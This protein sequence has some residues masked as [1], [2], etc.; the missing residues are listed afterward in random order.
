MKRNRNVILAAGAATLLLA[1]IIYA[2][3]FL[4]PPIAELYGWEQTSGKLQFN[5]TLTLIFYCVGGLFSGFSAK[6][7]APK[8][9]LLVSGLLVVC[10]LTIVSRLSGKSPLTLYLGYGA[11]T[12]TG[13]GI[14]Y[15]TLVAT[16]T[17]HFPDKKGLASGL[18]MLGFGFSAF[19]LGNLASALFETSFGWRNVFLIY[20][21][22]IGAVIMLAAFVIVPPE[23]KAEQAGVSDGMSVAESVRRGSYW[24]AFMFFVC[25]N[26]L[27]TTAIGMSTNLMEAVGATGALIT[28]GAGMVSVFNGVSR[29]FWGFLFDRLGIKK[30]RLVDIVV[31]MLSPLLLI[32]ALKAKSPALCFIAL[33][34]TGVAFAYSPTAT[35]NYL[36]SFYG[37]RSFNMNLSIHTLSLIPGSLFATITGGMEMMSAYILLACVAAVGCAL[38]A[39]TYKA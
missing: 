11:M 26:A 31:L 4:K 19:A 3:S 9:R 39:M 32:L 36:L 34:L 27:C 1:G 33:C 37:G 14:A 7:L 30:T 15:N 25:I 17:A 22:V 13:I 38:S 5:Y 10:G 8:I 6:V 20:G 28:V 16:V 23:T 21:L 18:L 29:L 35:T 24:R 2:W 12:G